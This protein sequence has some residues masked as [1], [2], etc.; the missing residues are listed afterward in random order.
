[1]SVQ[2][3]QGTNKGST[4]HGTGCGQ[5]GIAPNQNS[6]EHYKWPEYC[7]DGI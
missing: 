5:L 1:M 3:D 4:S 6:A 2:T 7:I